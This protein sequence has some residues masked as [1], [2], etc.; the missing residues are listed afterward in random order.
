MR[1]ACIDIT[2]AKDTGS[3]N[4]LPR[5]MPVEAK[6]GKGFLTCVTCSTVKLGTRGGLKRW[7]CF[8]GMSRNGLEHSPAALGGLVTLVFAVGIE[9]NVPADLRWAGMSYEAKEVRMKKHFLRAC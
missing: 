2:I 5:S 3:M 6:T 8:A 4:R 1:P 7:G 9:E